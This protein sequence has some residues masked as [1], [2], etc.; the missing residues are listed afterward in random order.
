M[1]SLIVALMLTLA[2]NVMGF[3]QTDETVTIQNQV[4]DPA[5]REDL[6]KA[7][8]EMRE[9]TLGAIR[10]ADE[11][12]QEAINVANK[13]HQE[14][15]DSAEKK[16]EE[17]LNQS[18][19][20]TDAKV[21]AVL[22]AAEMDRLERAEWW[23]GARIYGGAGVLIVIITISLVAFKRPNKT[24]EVRVVQT[25]EKNS[26]G[27]R[28]D[29]DIPSLREYSARNGNINPVPFI[30]TLHDGTKVVCEAQLNEES[31]PLIVSISGKKCF[32]RWKN[33][34]K[35]VIKFLKDNEMLAAS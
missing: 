29:P 18:K 20:D 12:A 31:S 32:I 35:A 16:Q 11:R 1:K 7:T 26:D 13:Q 15:L 9:A 5:S 34:V 33:R 27:I 8:L 3:A 17:I 4:P 22:S 14:M 19:A 30:L 28:V 25:T 23:R 24:V 10:A 6:E 2:Y 21:E